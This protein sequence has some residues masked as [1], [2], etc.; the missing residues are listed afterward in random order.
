MNK[1]KKPADVKGEA[2]GRNSIGHRHVRFV[3]FFLTFAQ[4]LA[5]C[6]VLLGGL[7]GGCEVLEVDDV[8]TDVIHL[9]L[10]RRD[11]LAA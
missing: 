5:D 4:L 11:H 9:A 7:R 8:E 1:R 3:I 6:H 10:D 2:N